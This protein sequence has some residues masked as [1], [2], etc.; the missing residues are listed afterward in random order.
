MHIHRYTRRVHGIIPFSES[1]SQTGGY[2]NQFQERRT[3]R[4][5]AGIRTT[6][7]ARRHITNNQKRCR[8][9]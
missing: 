5:N 9:K 6:I 7:M 2:P 4:H 3:E 8:G 1:I